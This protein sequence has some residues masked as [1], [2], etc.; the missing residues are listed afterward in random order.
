MKKA[1]VMLIGAILCGCLL[2]GCSQLP[3]PA[4]AADGAAWS[5][6][7]VTVGNIIGV[8]TPDSVEAQENS[9]GLADK[10]MYYAT[11]S[12]GNEMPYVNADGKDAKVYDAQFYLLLAGYDAAEKAE[13]ALADWQSMA[14]SQYNVEETAEAVYNGQPFTVMTYTYASETNPYQRGASA[15]GVY[16]NY[17]ISVEM[18]CQEDFDGDAQ[19]LLA[20]FLEHCHYAV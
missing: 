14:A 6:D 12:I 1:A 5:E 10:G 3:P 20:D 15:F 2:V 17:A 16:R 18:S 4:N 9:D 13:D 8:D 7:W 11:W 19:A